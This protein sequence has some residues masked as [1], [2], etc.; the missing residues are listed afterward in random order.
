MPAIVGV[1]T[2]EE[3]LTWL[4]FLFACKGVVLLA[5]LYLAFA[6]R[7]VNIKPLNDSRF[8][9]MSVYGIV[10]VS[11]A[12]T[13]IGFSLQHYPNT[14]YAI[15]GITVLLGT[16]MILGLAFVTKVYMA[17]C[18]NNIIIMHMHR[19]TKCIKIQRGQDV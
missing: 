5:G 3:S 6:T 8:I 4:S 17:M 11:I 7:K 9:A 14:Q 12:L 19:C 18:I 10:I 1:C 13:P 2:S 16:T 15:I